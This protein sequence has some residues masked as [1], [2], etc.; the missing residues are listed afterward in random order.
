MQIVTAKH[1]PEVRDHYG[2]V[3]GRIEGAKVL[4][5]YRKAINVD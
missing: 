4:E 2:G 1:W 5:L 3:S